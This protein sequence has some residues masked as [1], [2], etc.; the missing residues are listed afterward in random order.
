MEIKLNLTQ[1]QE[2]NLLSQLTNRPTLDYL[3]L[4]G[5]RQ[6]ACNEYYQYLDGHAACLYIAKQIRDKKISIGKMDASFIRNALTNNIAS[7]LCNIN[8]RMILSNWY[9]Q[10]SSYTPKGFVDSYIYCLQNGGVMDG[11]LTDGNQNTYKA[12]LGNLPIRI[13][14]VTSYEGLPEGIPI[15][16]WLSG[17][18]THATIIWKIGIYHHV[19]D[20]ASIERNKLA[21]TTEDLKKGLFGK[22]II[23]YEWLE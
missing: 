4:D 1:E 22:S 23:H 9:I 11:T 21:L 6:L 16:V 14:Q 10:K 3:T 20:T 5:L 7:T 12:M 8:A 17:N 13:K 19:I 15:R 18:G 2:S